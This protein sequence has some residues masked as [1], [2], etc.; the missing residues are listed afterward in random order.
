M[1]VCHQVNATPKTAQLLAIKLVHIGNYFLAQCLSSLLNCSRASALCCG[2]SQEQ[3]LPGE[4][5]MT[6]AMRCEIPVLT[7]DEMKK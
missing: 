6:G 5:S 1:S 3:A 4:V 7:P 2:P